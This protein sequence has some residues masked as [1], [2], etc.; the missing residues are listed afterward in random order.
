MRITSNSSIVK[1]TINL[2]IVRFSFESY[3]GIHGIISLLPSNEIDTFTSFDGSILYS[4]EVEFSLFGRLA[5]IITES[6][7]PNLGI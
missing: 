5:C 1:V 7:I 2:R 4:V 3:I 6:G